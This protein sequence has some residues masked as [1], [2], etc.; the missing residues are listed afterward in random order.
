[1]RNNLKKKLIHTFAILCCLMTFALVGKAQLIN[2]LKFETSF[3]FNIKNQKFPAGKY[4]IERLNPVDPRIL[5]LRGENGEMSHILFTNP[6]DRE[7]SAATSQIIF[8]HND[9]G[10]YLTKIWV[11]GELNGY[12]VLLNLDKQ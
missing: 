7:E 6:I 12:G 10:Y 11:D 4:T 9:E 3:D 2:R 5:I 8:K 1:M